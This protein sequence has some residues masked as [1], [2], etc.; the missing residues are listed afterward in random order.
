MRSIIA[1]FIGRLIMGL[2]AIVAAT[3]ALYFCMVTLNINRTTSEII[4]YVVLAAVII[5]YLVFFEKKV[6]KRWGN[7]KNGVEINS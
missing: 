1:K 5:P 2:I 7:K 3:T 6:I 4:S